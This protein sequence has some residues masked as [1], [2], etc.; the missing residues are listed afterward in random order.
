MD[1]LNDGIFTYIGVIAVAGFAVFAV[2]LLLT[3]LLTFLFF[4]NTNAIKQ[5]HSRATATLLKALLW[6][7]DILYIPSKKIT[8]MLSGN[9]TMIDVVA[10]EMRNILLKKEFMQIPYSQRVVLVPQCLRNIDCP[11][12]VNSVKGAQCVKCGKCKIKE[13]TEK[14][15]ELGYMGTYIAPGGGFVKRIIKSV[16]PRAVIG[17]G[18]P[19]EVNMGLLLVTSKGLACQ[20]VILLNSGCVETDV[21]LNTVYET[22]ELSKP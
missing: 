18:C 20:G 17:L 7:I 16:K 2:L 22:M 10:T 19:E 4:R 3:I 12:R 21:D 6:V 11:A 9:D 15:E 1:L 13:I 8:A 5:V 14:A